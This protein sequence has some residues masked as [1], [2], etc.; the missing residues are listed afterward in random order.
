MLIIT[1]EKEVNCDYNLDIYCLFT[2]L[3]TEGNRDHGD[4]VAIA[5]PIK[6]VAAL[7]MWA[8]EPAVE[9]LAATVENADGKEEDRE[10]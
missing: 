7:G 9:V 2:D 4:R 6:E 8:D 1:R 5:A 3:R 10:E